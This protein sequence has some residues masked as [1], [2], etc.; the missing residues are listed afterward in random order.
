MQKRTETV[1]G[2]TY[3][4][5]KVQTQRRYPNGSPKSS[6]ELDIYY[7]EQNKGNELDDGSII[8]H[9]GLNYYHVIQSSPDGTKKESLILK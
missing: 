8:L 6:K 2:V 3:E 5:T 7:S 9:E 1:N 4:V